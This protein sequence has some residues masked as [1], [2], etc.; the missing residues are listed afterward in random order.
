MA[1]VMAEGRWCLGEQVV[2]A[3]SC[4]SSVK[5]SGLSVRHHGD[6]SPDW[7]KGLIRCF[8]W[9]YTNFRRECQDQVAL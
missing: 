9:M 8:F 3:M 4:D 2:N 5:R 1:M 7:Q 6:V